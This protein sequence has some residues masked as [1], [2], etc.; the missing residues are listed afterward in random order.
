MQICIPFLLTLLLIYLIK[1]SETVK[2]RSVSIILI[3]VLVLPLM[4]VPFAVRASTPRFITIQGTRW[5]T[6]LTYLSLIGMGLTNADIAPLRHMTNLTALYLFDNQIT[7]ISALSGLTNLTHLGLTDNQIRNLAP[8]RN[9]TNLTHLW[10][11]RN[12]VIDLRPLAGLKNLTELRLE[13]NRV[14]NAQIDAL[15]ESLPNLPP[16]TPITGHE[17]QAALGMGINIGMALNANMVAIGQPLPRNPLHSETAFGE[18][19]IEPWHFEAIA[20]MGFDHVRI[21]VTWGIFTDDYGVIYK[22]WI[23]RVQEVVDMA[24]DAGLFVVLN[25]HN[26]YGSDKGIY[27]LLDTGDMV[28]AR[29]W[30]NN[31]WGQIAER[32]RNYPETLLFETF[33][34]PNR[35]VRGGWVWRSPSEGVGIDAQFAQRVNQANNYVLNAVRNSGGNNTRRV[36]V[37]T[38]AGAVTESIPYYE[39][40]DDAYTMM[41]VFWYPISHFDFSQ[42]EAAHRRGIPIYIRETAPMW[43]H[44]DNWYQDVVPLNRAVNWVNRYITRF[45]R[46]GIPFAMWNTEGNHGFQIFARSVG[47][48]NMPLT[49]AIFAAYG[50]E[51]GEVFVYPALFPYELPWEFREGDDFH[52]PW[53]IPAARIAIADFMVVEYDGYPLHGFGFSH[54]GTGNDRENSNHNIGARRV[55]HESGR[56]IFDLRGLPPTRGASAFL[57][58]NAWSVEQN[59]QVKRIYLTT[60]GK[61]YA[62]VSCADYHVDP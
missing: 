32:F 24:L 39:H 5:S 50:R 13:G 18:A 47:E 57:G 37:F 6:E 36:V 41:G 34:E 49:E 54:F 15:R 56:I 19:R 48:W 53:N 61:H 7:N 4:F 29:A 21:P 38:T 22:P 11:G 59:M 55:T 58:F 35:A 23:D 45:A 9:L 17:M 42:I 30:I 14:T 60:H 52:D 46:M 8:L 3:L 51:P 40:P 31:V 26:E 1:R 2:K 12:D 16:F 28:A 27:E 33:N 44:G 25:T 20:L 10:L 43:T 62:G